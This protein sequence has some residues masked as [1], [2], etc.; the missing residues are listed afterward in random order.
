MEIIKALE[1]LSGEVKRHERLTLVLVLA[2]ICLFITV[3]VRG[4][5][6]VHDARVND[7]A[8]AVLQAQVEKNAALAD[9]NARLAADYKDLATKVLAQNAQLDQAIA[10]RDAATRKQQVVDQTLSPSDLAARWQAIAKLSAGS[11]SPSLNG[12]FAVT[13]AGARQTVQQL[14]DVPRL[15]ADLKDKTQ[16]LVLSQSLLTAAEGRI[17]GLN[18][19]VAGLNLEIVDA[20][21]ACDARVK[22]VKDQARKSKG[23]WFAVGYAAGLLTKYVLKAATGL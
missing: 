11:V 22:V 3:K 8:Q 21:K 13:D 20:G 2:V 15:D 17:L 14:E 4:Y 10:S 9:S 19:Q 12:A 1:W 6:D 18:D 5:M 23:R 7:K 16:E